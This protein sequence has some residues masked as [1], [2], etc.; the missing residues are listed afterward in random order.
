MTGFT[1]QNLSDLIDE[2]VSYALGSGRFESINGHE[3][4]NSPGTGVTG[5][6]WMG[7]LMPIKKSGLAATSYCLSLM[8][9]VYMDFKSQPFDSID[10]TVT[11]AIIDMMSYVTGDFSF[12]SL[13]FVRNVDLIGQP[14]VSDGLTAIPGYVEI[15]RVIYRIVT[16]TIPVVINDMFVQTS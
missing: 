11:S 1:D 4:K 15:D 14:D 5:A 13:G 3:P 10:P 2:I 16:L 6:V 9:R 8:F 7:P 12:Q